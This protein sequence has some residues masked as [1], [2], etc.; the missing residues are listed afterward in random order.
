[1]KLY[2]VVRRD[3]PPGARAAQLCH[4]LRAFVEAHPAEDQAWFRQ[5]NTLV[6]LEVE[7]EQRLALLLSQ[8]KE[9]QIACAD[10]RE[11]DLG[12]SLTA[13]A[14]APGGKKLVRGLP[15]ALLGTVTQ[16]AE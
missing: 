6:L 16:L 11:P 10:F 4:A 7:S 5:S 9:K 12:D 3:L 2:L 15:L 1:M 14:V 13:I 8:A